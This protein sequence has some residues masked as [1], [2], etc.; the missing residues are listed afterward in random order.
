MTDGNVNLATLG[1]S[2]NGT[3]VIGVAQFV[4]FCGLG[5]LQASTRAMR[6]KCV[7]NEISPFPLIR[8]T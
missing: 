7:K 2:A 4:R 5:L 1:L 6:I 8:I 3:V